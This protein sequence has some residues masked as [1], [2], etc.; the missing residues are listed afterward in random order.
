MIEVPPHQLCSEHAVGRGAGREHPGEIVAEGLRPRPGLAGLATL[1]R[2]VVGEEAGRGEGAQALEV[3][4]RAP[5]K[6]GVVHGLEVLGGAPGDSGGRSASQRSVQPLR[7]V[8][9]TR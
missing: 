9:Q 3:V 5:G 1:G 7:G 2:E 6:T 8:A 4:G